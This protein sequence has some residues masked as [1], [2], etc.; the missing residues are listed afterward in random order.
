MA[1]TAPYRPSLVAR[2]NDLALR[3]IVAT[4]TPP[5]MTARIL[6][7]V[8]TSVYEA[9]A[10]WEPRAKS[11]YTREFRSRRAISNYEEEV[12]EAIAFAAYRALDAYF[13]QKV[14]VEMGNAMLEQFMQDN[15]YDPANTTLDPATPAG[16][17]NRCAAV[18]LDRFH[19]DG[20]NTFKTINPKNFYADYTDY[21]PALG[22]DD[23][24]PENLSDRWQPLK[25]PDGTS[26]QFLVPH[27]G[28]VQPF[29]MPYGS[30]FRPF[31]P[32][33]K[34][35]SDKL[36][37]MAEEIVEI[38]GKLDTR[39]KAIAEYWMDG[40]GS[41]TPPGHW[42]LIA[43]WV[44][45]RDRHELEKDVKMFFALSNA[46][47]DAGIAA[48]DC[49]RAYDTVRPVT[50][51]RNWY[52]DK[53]ITAW[54]GPDSGLTGVSM[55]GKDWK[56]YQ[57]LDFVTPPFAEFVSGH[58]TF[59]SAAAGILR[60]FTGRD[61]YGGE[62][63]VSRLDIDQRDLNPP[64]ILQWNSFSEAA[65]EAG[66]SRLYGGIHFMEG[67]LRGLEMGE[68]IAELVWKKANALWDGDY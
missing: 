42:C 37:K 11:L 47:M 6:A 22:M 65:R 18:A 55:K 34:W 57:K 54:G 45:A 31:P 15:G 49:K 58:S 12:E 25:K 44:A 51:I 67:N 14:R 27:W 46:L 2:L 19:G 43:Q 33:A 7:I 20:A 60:R 38:S 36:K 29:S 21:K 52:K 41:V 8:H 40:P 17:G 64:V 50:L 53:N 61:Y 16:T 5:P 10:M 32:P 35:D 39:Q 30:W 3:A 1:Y 4:Q 13:G 66:I 26:Q 62:T 24:I 48:W 23:D 9:W 68:K 59:S 28:L 56:P 63:T